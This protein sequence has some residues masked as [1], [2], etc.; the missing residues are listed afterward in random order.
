L[1]P[2]EAQRLENP[3]SA[4]LELHWQRDALV[5]KANQGCTAWGLDGNPRLRLWK[6]QTGPRIHSAKY[7][8]A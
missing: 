2:S 3:Q 7:L 1:E 8:G 5:E 6:Q 4:T